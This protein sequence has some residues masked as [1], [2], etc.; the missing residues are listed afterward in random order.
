MTSEPEIKLSLGLLLKDV[1]QRCRARKKLFW[2]ASVV[3]WAF[4]TLGF[5]VLGG[6][7][8]P[9]FLLWMAAFY[10]FW[11]VFTRLALGREP[12]Y[13]VKN[14]WSTLIPFTRIL[15]I[16]FVVATLFI[17]IPFAPYI[18]DVPVEVKENYSYFQQRYMQDSDAYD[19]VLNAGLILVLPVVF[20]RPVMAWFAAC[21][22]RS[23]SMMTAWEK[24]RGHYFLMCVLALIA[25]AAF[26]ALRYAVL[27]W[28][29]PCPLVWIVAAP[30]LVVAVGILLRMYAVLYAAA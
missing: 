14:L 3:V 27:S 24:T 4:L 23:W 25:D 1:W 20:I 12:Y 8:N 18:M 2:G 29:L 9:W 22:G 13:S 19:L 7:S 6:W 26:W 28:S 15:F 17:L 30:L 5:C 16:A 10:Y 11:Y 21:L